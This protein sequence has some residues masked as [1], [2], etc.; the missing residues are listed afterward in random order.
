MARVTCGFT[1]PPMILPS[2]DGRAGW[3][4]GHV[5]SLL[6]TGSPYGANTTPRWSHVGLTR[7]DGPP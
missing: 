3:M 5:P 6:A 7:F 4:K 2:A 1:K